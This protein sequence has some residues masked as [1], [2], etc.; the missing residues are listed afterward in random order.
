MGERVD[1]NCHKNIMGQINYRK[2]LMGEIWLKRNVFISNHKVCIIFAENI[3]I[4]YS[5][6]KVGFGIFTI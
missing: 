1:F 5:I 2:N 4:F 3:I 6:L